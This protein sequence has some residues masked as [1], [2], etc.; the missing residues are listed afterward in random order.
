MCMDVGLPRAR[1]EQFEGRTNLS[2]P[3]E[4]WF[5][6]NFGNQQLPA[7]KTVLKTWETWSESQEKPSEARKT[8]L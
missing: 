3:R 1:E 2:E 4:A 5:D 6:F 7:E 8:S